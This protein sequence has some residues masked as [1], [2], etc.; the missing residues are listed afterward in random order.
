MFHTGATTAREAA[1]SGPW[2]WPTMAM[3]T[4]LYTA[5]SMALPKAAPRYLK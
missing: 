2:Y 5:A 4:R 3:S 1:P